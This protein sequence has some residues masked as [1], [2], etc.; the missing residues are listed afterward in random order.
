M[1]NKPGFVTHLLER[2]LQVIRDHLQRVFLFLIGHIDCRRNLDL[3]E[4]FDTGNGQAAG[5][6]I[7]VEARDS[8]GVQ[9]EIAVVG[10]TVP[11]S[12]RQRGCKHGDDD[13]A[14]HDH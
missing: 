10:I 14:A 1:R 8:I 6:R 2:Q 5:S 12:M 13:K 7:D 3:V 9:L 11:C 4:I